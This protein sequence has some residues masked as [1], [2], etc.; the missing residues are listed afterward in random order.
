MKMCPECWKKFEEEGMPPNFVKRGTGMACFGVTLC[1]ICKK[2]M[3]KF[4]SVEIS[5]EKLERK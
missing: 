3:L 2:R 1:E 5:N 4:V